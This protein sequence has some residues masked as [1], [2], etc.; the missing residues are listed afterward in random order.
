MS[1]PQCCANPP[2]ISSGNRQD[3]RIEVIGGL[4]SYTA[5]SPASKLAVIL[6]ADIYGYEAP[7]LRQIAEKVAAAGFYVVVPD[8][9]Y[10]DPYL[11]DMQLSSWFPNH[12]P[13]KGCEDARKVVADLKAKGASAVGAAGFCWGGMTVSK[14]SAYGEIEAAVIL[15]PGPLSEDD[16]HATKVPTA[17]L[18]AEIDDYSPPEQMKKLGEILSA[19][20]VDNFV[21]IYPGVVHGWTTRYKDDDEHAVKSAMEAHADMLNWFTKYLKSG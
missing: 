5:G 17:I 21:K 13:A 19:K 8:F 16:I 15:H 2:D 1:G 10:G 4:T 11:P 18:A 14:L 3:D 9:F 20:L 7:K 6:I 12:L